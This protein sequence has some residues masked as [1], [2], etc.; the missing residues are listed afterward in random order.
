MFQQTS[1]LSW[2]DVRSIAEQF[3]DTIQTLTPEIFTEMEGIAD[4]AGVGLLDI[5]A[6]NCRS[7][8]M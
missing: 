5:V 4:G 2:P 8:S 1:K 7:E 6:L 3:S